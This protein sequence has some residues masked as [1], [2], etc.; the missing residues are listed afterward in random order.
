[1]SRTATVSR[2]ATVSK[3]VAPSRVDGQNNTLARSTMTARKER[4]AEALVRCARDPTQK[5]LMNPIVSRIILHNQRSRIL[6]LP[7]DETSHDRTNTRTLLSILRHEHLGMT[8][9]ADPRAETTMPTPK[10]QAV[11]TNVACNR[12]AAARVTIM[13]HLLVTTPTFDSS[14]L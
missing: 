8:T 10:A 9:D 12:K 4:G 1:M 6:L 5:L 7:L 3:T 11:T 2:R 14:R 13:D